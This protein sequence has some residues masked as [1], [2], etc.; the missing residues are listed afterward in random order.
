MMPEILGAMDKETAGL[1]RTEYRKRGIDFYLDTKVT[2]V[3][4]EGVTIGKDGK[5]HLSRPTK[6]WSVWAGKPVS[7]G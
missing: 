4:K 6:C 1:L 7:A 2:A 5:R 3:G